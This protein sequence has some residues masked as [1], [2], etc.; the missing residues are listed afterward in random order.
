MVYGRS[1]LR[2]EDE[3]LVPV[4]IAEAFHTLQLMS[5]REEV[6]TLL[7]EPLDRR[8]IAHL[9]Q[10][11]AFAAGSEMD[12]KQMKVRLEEVLALSGLVSPTPALTSTP[13]TPF[14]LTRQ[15]R[16]HSEK[17]AFLYG[18]RIHKRRRVLRIA[19]LIRRCNPTTDPHTIT[20][21]L[22]RR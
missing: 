15:T 19:P 4:E 10:F 2:S 13:L 8:V 16:R 7:S 18:F 12:L 14:K 5:L 9:L 11:L 3:L 6:E 22:T 17:G 1:H 21:V 20:G